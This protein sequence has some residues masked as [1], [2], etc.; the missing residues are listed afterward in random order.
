M[1]LEESGDGK[2]QDQEGQKG[3]KENERIREETKRE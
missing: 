2:M 3:H 1:Q